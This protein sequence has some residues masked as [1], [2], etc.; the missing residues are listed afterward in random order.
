M[1]KYFNG[2]IINLLP[3]LQLA[4]IS[5]HHLLVWR[6]T[7]TAH[8]NI[9]WYNCTALENEASYVWVLLL[10]SPTPPLLLRKPWTHWP[11]RH[12]AST[13]GIWESHYS[14][15]VYSQGNHT[16]STPLSLPRNKAKYPNSTYII[17]TSS[18]RKMSGPNKSKFKNKKWWFL[19]MQRNQHNNI[20]IRK[21]KV[22]WHH[23]SN[24][25]TL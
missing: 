16:E 11:T 23:Q 10:P 25:V 15:A 3:P 22:L 18:R 24:I 14:K 4:P 9:W 12:I 13:T 8:Y 19:Q 1:L 17:F 21:D 6:L 20:G 7:F 5:K 2:S